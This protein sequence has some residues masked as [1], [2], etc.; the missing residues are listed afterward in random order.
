VNAEGLGSASF[1]CLRILDSRC[2]RFK[3]PCE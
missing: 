2:L 1:G 3:R